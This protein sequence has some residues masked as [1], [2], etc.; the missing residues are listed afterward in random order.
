MS[1]KTPLSAITGIQKMVLSTVE[2]YINNPFHSAAE[3]LV[4]AIKRALKDRQY[5]FP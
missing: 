5:S 1:I 3:D 2:L 4:T